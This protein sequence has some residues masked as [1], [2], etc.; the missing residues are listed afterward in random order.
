[1]MSSPTFAWPEDMI[2]ETMPEISG[3]ALLAMSSSSFKMMWRKPSSRVSCKAGSHQ[4]QYENATFRI[5]VPSELVLKLIEVM[6]L[7]QFLTKLRKGRGRE[8]KLMPVLRL[9]RQLNTLLEVCDDQQR[10]FEIVRL[11][12][13]G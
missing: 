12:A 1:M 6:F 11:L 9:R 5:V 13:A 10:R 7:L 8:T 3:L 4:P 2:W